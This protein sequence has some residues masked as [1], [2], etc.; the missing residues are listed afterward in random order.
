VPLFCSTVQPVR[1]LLS[2]STQNGF[3]FWIWILQSKTFIAHSTVNCVMY[4][5]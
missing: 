5:R 3:S 2:L 1:Q 4:W